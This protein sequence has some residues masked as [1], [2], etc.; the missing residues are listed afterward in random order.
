MYSVKKGGKIGLIVFFLLIIASGFFFIKSDIPATITGAAIGEGITEMSIP[1][2]GSSVEINLDAL[3]G[4]DLK[5]QANCGGVTAC[6]C[7]DTLIESWNMGGNLTGCG[8]D[9]VI[10]G[11][12]NI[13]L[14]CAGNW[15]N[16]TN[17]YLSSGITTNS[18]WNN[19]TIK[20]CNVQEFEYG[21]N[22]V[23]FN[24]SNWVIQNNNLS[25][26]YTR[27][28]Y[29]GSIDSLMNI[30]ISDNIITSLDPVNNDNVAI[31]ISGTSS[32]T[33]VYVER[34]TIHSCPGTTNSYI[35]IKG[36]TFRNNLLYNLSGRVLQSSGYNHIINN[37]ITNVSNYAIRGYSQDQIIN[38][39]VTNSGNNG[40]Y[41]VGDSLSII[42]NTLFNNSLAGIYCNGGTKSNLSNNNLYSNR[43]NSFGRSVYLFNCQNISVTNNSMY[44]NSYFGIE[45]YN[46]DNNQLTNNTIFNNSQGGIKLNSGS[47]NN[48]VTS[49]ILL[50]NAPS[51]IQVHIESSQNNQINNNTIAILID[52]NQ[53][54][55]I[56]NTLGSNNLTHNI[57]N[58]SYFGIII[59]TSNGNILYRNRVN[60]NYYGYTIHN[61]NSN[62]LNE[63][64]AYNSTLFT[65][66]IDQNSSSNSFL[67]FALQDNLGGN[68]TSNSTGEINYLTNSYFPKEKINSFGGSLYYQWQVNISVN[69][70]L[71]SLYGANVSALNKYNQLFQSAITNGMGNT[72]LT[73]P[74]AIFNISG[75]DELNNYTLIAS[76]QGYTTNTS[77]NLSQTNSTSVILMLNFTPLGCGTV[78]QSSSLNTNLEVNGSCFVIN[79]SNIV[80]DGGG[81]TIRGNGTGTGI[82]IYNYNNIT[83][84]NVT[85]INFSTGI[86][87]NYSSQNL[88]LSNHISYSGNGLVGYLSNQSNITLN[89][90]F[91]NTNGTILIT[92]YQN[93]IYNNNYSYN[94]NHS[95]DNGSNHWNSSLSCDIGSRQNIVGDDCLGGNYWEGYNISDI[96]VNGIDDS[97]YLISGGS[98][99][100]YL[101]LIKLAEASCG[102]VNSSRILPFGTILSTATTCF[103]I[104]SDNIV[105]DGNGATLIGEIT[106]DLEAGINIQNF[107]N[108]TIKN[109]EIHNFSRG[110]LG[111]I[112]STSSP[113]DIILRNNNIYYYGTS[114]SHSGG[115]VDFSYSNEVTLINNT[116]YMYGYTSS[117]VLPLDSALDTISSNNLY[118]E[119]NTFFSE[120]SPALDLRD[121]GMAQFVS[122]VIISN[123][124]YDIYLTSSA[125]NITFTNV[126]SENELNF[127]TVG[128]PLI[129]IKKFVDV[130]VTNSSGNSI[131]NASVY[132]Y[133]VT[134][135]LDDQINTDNNGIARLTLT[136][137]FI[138]GNVRYYLSN[139]HTIIAL[140][141]GFTESSS[142]YNLI[143][144]SNL[145]T[146]LII[147]PISCG[148]NLNQSASLG[149]NMSS[150]GDCFNITTSGVRLNGNGYH[151]IGSGVGEGLTMIGVSGINISNLT[152]SNF[153]QGIILNY[154]NDSIILG[155]NLSD[156]QN[157]VV[158]NYSNNN[159]II[160]STLHNNNV[161]VYASNTGGT[162][163]YLIN[164]SIDPENVT[165]EGTAN[166]FL[167]WIV[168]VNV[169]SNYGSP[170]S[171][172]NVSGYYN[173]TSLIDNSE[174]TNEGGIARLYLSEWK[175][176]S[177]EIVYYTHNVSA[178][179]DHS[180]LSSSNSTYI[181]VSQTHNAQVGINL[182]LNCTTPTSGMYINN[183]T[184]LCP[185]TFYLTPSYSG[186]IFINNSNLSLMCVNTK[187]LYN[188]VGTGYIFTGITINN[189]NS[190]LIDG[191]EIKGFGTGLYLDNVTNSSFARNIFPLDGKSIYFELSSNNSLSENIFNGSEIYL[192]SN[193]GHNVI[194]NN[195]FIG[196]YGSQ[197]YSSDNIFYHNV[198]SSSAGSTSAYILDYATNSF[199]TSINVSGNLSSQGN[200]WDDYC[201]KGLD[202]NGDGYAD[203]PTTNT[204]N[205]YPYNSTTSTLFLGTG[206]DYGPKIHDC[207]TV[208]Q[209]GNNGG[210][211]SSSTTTATTTTETPQVATP[212]GTKTTTTEAYTAE[213]TKQ[214]LKTE[215]T[216]KQAGGN[217]QVTFNLENT[218]KKR[219]LLFPGLEQQT[220]DPYFIIT[221]KTLGTG[222]S[223][224]NKISSLYYSENSI[225]G[226]LLKAEILNPEQIVLNPGEKVEKTLEIKEGL[227]IPRQI[228]IQFTT[229]G[230][231]VYEQEVKSE[232][233]SVSGTA[234]DVDVE[235]K[236]IDV[237]AVIVSEEASRE[238][239]AQAQDGIT[240]AAI[241]DFN[242][243]GEDY[244][245]E[246]SITKKDGSDLL[247]GDLYGPYLIK[248]GKTLVFAQ[249]LKYDLNQYYGENLIQA[250]IYHQGQ[251]IAENEFSVNLS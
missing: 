41:F 176:N 195:S 112:Y 138:S 129:F 74:E 251:V 107:S 150:I 242:P 113:S 84:R 6:N 230:E 10:I 51:G 193:S 72:M 247:F 3:S 42:G 124:S 208:V 178:N 21:I 64:Q 79:G 30:N 233:K 70:S 60:F 197:L 160:D 101:P 63:E 175:K 194:Q 69:N 244:L 96:D 200:T 47:S 25:L 18:V 128:D 243:S 87:M 88:I 229:F 44:N 181:N 56:I 250:K 92:S 139:N 237:Y 14:D 8:G 120:K 22:A 174:L 215:L 209:L 228:K 20:N 165:T 33:N 71:G 58:G 185:G 144:N 159:R 190:V 205:D 95:W 35:N 39:T 65:V 163:N 97:P 110:I 179:Y 147:N 216:T 158:F 131:Q 24:I 85:L 116:I 217:T 31:D 168:D 115:G 173:G 199:N 151:L 90:F 123:L 75:T 89:H 221:R 132:G 15:I 91:N 12:D 2:Q 204:S 206:A 223:L 198:F 249:Q 167:Q 239:E 220:D 226:K 161:P 170:L 93:I 7:G 133:D 16:G 214:Y 157:G 119:N 245:L 232:K 172:V 143:N 1:D 145:S 4:S 207:V 183:N 17:G 241:V 142:S 177:T 76:I 196:S 149:S 171:S 218:G 246:V 111:N 62:N 191:C 9:G 227:V 100:D 29:I 40:I 118:S 148:M 52:N 13:I 83:L 82:D 19:I 57:I 222:N 32:N 23:Y 127:T 213:E 11:A 117:V 125:V 49:N 180:P 86:M 53:T 238:I 187:I 162:N 55:I 134:N 43:Q 146:G 66:W 102:N 80:I 225:T 235:N 154:V 182:S 114:S 219:M 212:T 236:A 140:K 248:G 105:L 166:V 169:T 77:I 99:Y 109:F 135:N 34:N 98:N 130:E 45:L 188:I 152:L 94:Q 37:T 28:I 184:I 48:E 224:F 234:V 126:S 122:D 73:L 186:T 240:G 68:I 192:D 210:G 108:I 61:S 5:I 202:L 78:N 103:N 81:L 164:V 121:S 137:S 36:V 189:Q 50:N 27:G 231:T 203:A 106:N 46:G 67:N 54:G 156:N 153:S 38:N 136:E 26:A 155:L 141:G 104:T 211:G 201:D 59:N